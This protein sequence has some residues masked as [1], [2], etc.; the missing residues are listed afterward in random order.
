MKTPLSLQ[1]PEV[2]GATPAGVP[3]EGV[4]PA[5][6]T[7]AMRSA[8]AATQRRSR[9]ERATRPKVLVSACILTAA[10]LVW[11]LAFRLPLA[12]LPIPPPVVQPASEPG[13]GALA[14]FEPSDVARLRAQAQSATESLVPDRASFTQLLARIESEAQRTGLRPQLNVA[15]PLRALAGFTNLMAYPVAAR[16]TFQDQDAAPEAPYATLEDWL[17]TLS[18][19]P[20]RTEITGLTLEG[21]GRGLTAAQVEFRIL[22]L[23]DHGTPDSK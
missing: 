15:P 22:G 11:S 2:P 3:V 8:P 9:L 13:E 4:R 14:R 7:T 21:D 18:H 5:T 20:Q 1:L 12:R 23:P 17:S 16:L 10:L 6:A 19:L